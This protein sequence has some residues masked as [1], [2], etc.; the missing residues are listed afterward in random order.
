MATE[1]VTLVDVLSVPTIGAKVL[2]HLRFTGAAQSLRLSCSAICAVVGGARGV[3]FSSFEF[4]AALSTRETFKVLVFATL[5]VDRHADG[6]RMYSGVHV[7][8]HSMIA[9]SFAKRGVFR[10]TSLDLDKDS[11][12]PVMKA[13]LAAWECHPMFERVKSVNLDGGLSKKILEVGGARGYKR[14]K[15]TAR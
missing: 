2:G 4:A 8:V 13:L 15:E 3:V 7:K 9:Q 10:P 14:M 11:S 12:F 1:Q 6:V 5:Q